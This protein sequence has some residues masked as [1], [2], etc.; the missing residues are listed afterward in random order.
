MDYYYQKQN[1][2][3]PKS[4]KLLGC[5]IGC[6]IAFG[7]LLLF[8][9]IIAYLLFRSH[10]PVSE[11]QFF[12]PDL[13]GFARFQLDALQKEPARQLF[14]KVLKNLNPPQK[15]KQSSEPDLEGVWNALDVLLH[16]RHFFYLYETPEEDKD[17]LVVVNI[18]RLSWIFSSILK[19]VKNAEMERIPSPPNVKATCLRLK[20][21][22]GPVF[23]AISSN[24]VL[25][26]NSESR[27]SH[28]L[29]L[30]HSEKP[31]GNLSPMAKSLLPDDNPI[32]MISGF[33]LWRGTFA[34]Y[35]YNNLLEEYPKS[36][37]ILDP[38]YQILSGMPVQGVQSSMNL[39][40]TDVLEINA[41]FHFSTESEASLYAENLTKGISS[42]E[43]PKD[44]HISFLPEGKKAHVSILVPGVERWLEKTLKK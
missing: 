35:L 38:L 39:S 34:A 42:L 26:S 5:L 37:D 30:L 21:T 16:K 31:S 15:G 9:I 1:T 41:S 13:I 8:L 29:I 17:Y 36:R 18:K 2:A 7:L 23:I 4:R 12:T 3:K 33:I 27:L 6:L 20:K 40:T 43:I 14:H 24:V 11:E 44:L 19:D 25:I 32:N 22:D 10:P 28:S